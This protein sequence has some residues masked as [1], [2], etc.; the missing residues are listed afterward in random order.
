[1]TVSAVGLFSWS[2]YQKVQRKKQSRRRNTHSRIRRLQKLRTD[3]AIQIV[4]IKKCSQQLPHDHSGFL[5][6]TNDSLKK[7]LIRW[8]TVEK[9]CNE[10]TQMTDDEK[11]ETLFSLLDI[12]GNG[13]IDAFELIEFRF[14]FNYVYK[15]GISCQSL[16]QSLCSAQRD[17]RSFDKDGDSMLSI[18]EF[19][20]LVKSFTNDLTD[21]VSVPEICE[22]LVPLL[23]CMIPDTLNL[24]TPNDAHH[25]DEEVTSGTVVVDKHDKH[26]RKIFDLFEHD[27]CGMI[28]K[29]QVLR[30]LS[31]AI[32][33]DAALY[34]ETVDCELLDF[35]SFAQLLVGSLPDQTKQINNF[36]NVVHWNMLRMLVTGAF[37]TRQVPNC[38][39]KQPGLANEPES[40]HSKSSPIDRVA[41]FSASF[42][43]REK[44]GKAS[45]YLISF[46][47]A[48]KNLM[49][50][51]R[52]NLD[53]LHDFHEE[54]NKERLE[55][56]FSSIDSNGEGQVNALELADSLRKV[57][58]TSTVYC[59]FA[60]CVRTA[61]KIVAQF[62]TTGDAMLN[63]KEYETYL[64]DRANQLRQTLEAVIECTMTSK[65]LCTC[66]SEDHLEDYSV[67]KLAE[68]VKL[69]ESF[70]CGDRVEAMQTL[71]RLLDVHSSGTIAFQEA[72][73]ALSTISDSI[74]CEYREIMKR[75]LREL[76]S[77]I[78]RLDQNEYLEF[79]SDL[80]IDC[81]AADPLIMFDD[82]LEQLT[83]QRF[84]ELVPDAFKCAA[85]A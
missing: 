19:K 1:M 44:P 70:R 25:Q 3:T 57:F 64:Q 85:A 27:E 82:L 34:D 43:F 28:Q 17:I 71:F 35:D 21:S 56:L 45:D 62:D 73:I 18:Y 30:L 9:C 75:R 74:E 39:S 24:F 50:T 61:V 10:L 23:P 60:T 77:G 33:A 69:R 76:D 40:L 11:M 54:G 29:A 68:E 32:A 36:L 8:Q 22:K 81:A 13:F 41:A 16:T 84:R 58:K 66:E 46:Q 26:L 31:R 52:K 6:S 72:V 15:H 63:I 20:N 51:T 80:V 37:E 2:V 83:E 78:G 4:Q 48:A 79:I 47:R 12:D 55:R 5:S 53:L 14:C 49:L 67:E 38:E 59:D 42:L 65:F 7:R